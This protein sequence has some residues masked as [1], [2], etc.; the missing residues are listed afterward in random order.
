MS[1]IYIF[2]GYNDPFYHKR[3]VENVIMLQSHALGDKKKFYISFGR[4]T[5]TTTVAKKWG[6]ITA[7]TIKKDIFRF[8]SL[9]FIIWKLAKKYKADLFIHSHNYQL[10]ACCIYKID[11]FTVH[12]GLTYLCKCLKRNYI[13]V[14]RNIEKLIYYRAL[15]VHFI[16]AFAKENALFDSKYNYKSVIIN[17]S[18]PLEAINKSLNVLTNDRKKDSVYTIFSVRS[19]EI[20]SRIDLL[21]NV[22]EECLNR[23]IQVKF[24]VAG[25]G[26]LFNKYTN[27]IKQK[28]LSNITL[29]GF[30]DDHD[31]IRKYTES[32]LVIVPSEY[33]EG[34]GLPI[35]EAYLFGKPVIASN[36]CAIPEIIMSKNLL[37]EN[38]VEFVIDKITF[39]LRNK[40]Q[41][42]NFESI[43]DYYKANFSNEKIILSYRQQLYYN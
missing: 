42:F 25:Q 32:D 24:V 12:D 36:K 18:T 22:C 14:F 38:E 21:I 2:I 41:I 1:K 26:H 28:K 34:F 9:N 17:N 27:I 19:M 29:L 10:S 35:I 11:V 40:E 3:G 31:L 7:I 43:V 23:N 39:C 13:G 5:D 33:G 6:D 30:I 37:F 8:I 4:K 16:S 20:R 15:K